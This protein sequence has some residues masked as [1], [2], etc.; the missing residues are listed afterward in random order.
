MEETLLT[1]GCIMNNESY[2]I[3]IGAAN[4]DIHG[5]SYKKLVM[6]DSNPGHIKISSGGVGRNIAE[7]LSKLNCMVKL[8]TVMGDDPYSKKLI[9]DCM[10][11][12]IDIKESMV[13]NNSSSPIYLSIIED[14]GD[15]KLSLCD[16]EILELL[17]I[18]FLQMKHS[19]IENAEII[20]IDTNLRKDVIEYIILNYKH[21]C[22]FVDTVSTQKALKISNF[23]GLLDTIKLNLLEEETLS[24][25]S[26]TDFSELNKIG[27]FF[28][29]KG[30]SNV[31]IT[32]G[33][34]GVYYKNKNASQI[35]GAP[36]IKVINAN[37]AG[38]AFTAGL[39]YSR[40]K[41][42][43]IDRSLKFSIAASSLALIHENTINP[44][45]STENVYLIMKEMNLC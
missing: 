20:L 12:G 9:Q 14:D 6:G 27:D 17:D 15:M 23:I 42:F 32:L 37:G 11:S 29:S 4:I 19:V 7:N 5:F 44:N 16:T 10:D 3:V 31:F 22:I 43:D 1:M 30:A 28:I 25:M 18:S 36:L 40:L 33:K 24:A 13:V 41:K 26:I 39:I 34:D 8:L 2:A 35:L 45:M 38:D 21:K